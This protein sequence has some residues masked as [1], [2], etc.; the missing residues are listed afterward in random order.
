MGGPSL[1]FRG[2]PEEDEE[3][4]YERVNNFRL[5]FFLDP[6]GTLFQNTEAAVSP[7]S[8]LEMLSY[9]YNA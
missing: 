8:L 7:K 9:Q 4:E 3:E 1:S 5:G 2:Q 6:G